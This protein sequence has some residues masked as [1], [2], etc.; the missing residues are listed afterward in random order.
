MEMPR[1][2]QSRP[3]VHVPVINLAAYT[4]IGSVGY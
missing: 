2:S 1:L 3:P 4:M